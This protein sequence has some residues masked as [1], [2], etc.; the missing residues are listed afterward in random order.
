[1]MTTCERLHAVRHLWILT[2]VVMFIVIVLIVKF[3][4]KVIFSYFFFI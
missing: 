2:G 4:L 1:M 3:E